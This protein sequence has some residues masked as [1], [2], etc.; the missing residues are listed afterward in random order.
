MRAGVSLMPQPLRIATRK[1]PLALWQAKYVAG[2]LCT[3]HPE[4][5]V[6]LVEVTTSGDRLLSAP[7]A[8]IGGKGLF[9]KELEM[10]LHKGQS[11]I[12]VHSMKDVVVRLP[13]EFTISAICARED[14][15]DAFVSNDYA[16][17]DRLPDGARIGTCSLRRQ[18]Q[19]LNKYPAL[20]VLN[21]RGNV[22]SRLRKLDA[23]EFD[24]IILAAAGLKRLGMVDR[25]KY[26]IPPD[27]SL[28]AVGQGA[29]GIE[30]RRDDNAVNKLLGPLDHAASRCCV[31]AERAMNERLDGGCQVPIGAYAQIV[32]DQLILAGLVGSIDGKTV[33]RTRVEGSP[34][35]PT[36]LGRQ[37][38][39]K[40][41]GLGAREILR[42]VF[43]PDIS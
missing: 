28:P 29:V 23:G 31:E 33:I 24:A 3:H 5:R 42:E 13:E 15:L 19:I 11:D 43:S 41:I 32:G 34:A 2:Q 22:N 16:A 39:D 30:S 6:E 7:L 1:S 40:L 8:S 12:A 20:E 26:S 25:I 14:P 17:L 4:L 21:L 10:S 27:V 9:M 36:A 35:E 18:A 37:A 38:A